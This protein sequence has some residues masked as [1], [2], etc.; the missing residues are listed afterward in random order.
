M[1]AEDE[2]QIGNIRYGSQ[3]VAPA[4]AYFSINPQNGEINITQSLS[5]DRRTSYTVS[6]KCTRL[7]RPDQ[8]QNFSLVCDRKTTYCRDKISLK[9]LEFQNLTLDN[10]VLV[11]LRVTAVDDAEPGRMATADVTILVQRNANAPRFERENYRVT[12]SDRATLGEPIA[13][14][15]ATDEDG[16]STCL[17]R[18]HTGSPPLEEQTETLDLLLFLGTFLCA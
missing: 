8:E 5:T 18:F 13:N 12:V 14:I 10:F 1:L 2:D 9:N 7:W 15:T 6:Y 16:V 17:S 3:G 11:Q 4:P